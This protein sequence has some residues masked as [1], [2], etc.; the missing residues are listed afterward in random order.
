MMT[1]IMSYDTRMR[2]AEFAISGFAMNMTGW[3]EL[4]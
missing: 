4:G 2:Y 1:M 3:L